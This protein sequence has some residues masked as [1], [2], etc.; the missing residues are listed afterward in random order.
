MS[1]AVAARSAKTLRPGSC[2]RRVHRTPMGPRIVRSV[3]IVHGDALGSP[4]LTASRARARVIAEPSRSCT[5]GVSPISMSVKPA[6]VLRARTPRPER[7][8]RCGR[9]G[10]CRSAPS[11]LPLS[12]R[13]GTAQRFKRLAG[14]GPHPRPVADGA[15]AARVNGPRLVPGFRARRSREAWERTSLVWVRRRV[16]FPQWKR[17]RHT[18]L[19]LYDRG[20]SKLA[21]RRG[22]TIRRGEARSR[23]LGIDELPSAPFRAVLPA[24]E[25]DL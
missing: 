17:R 23:A 20:T 18:L 15:R 8:G 12:H 16:V 10:S 21:C 4:S 14:S 2:S 22:T 13:R 9:C 3:P 11:A 24:L 25:V 19:R 7:R 1:G 6:S 5:R